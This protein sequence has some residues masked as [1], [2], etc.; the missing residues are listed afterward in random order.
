LTCVRRNDLEVVQRVLSP[1]EEGVAL[2]IALELQIPVD[3]E[4]GLAAIGVDLD[5]VVD[6]QFNRLKRVDPRG[7]A[8]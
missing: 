2:H 5:A 4:G 7:F 8:A 3:E 1:L 6:D